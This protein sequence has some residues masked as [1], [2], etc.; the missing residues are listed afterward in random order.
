MA[1]AKALTYYDLAT[2]RAVKSFIV[3]APAAN[4]IKLFMAVIYVFSQ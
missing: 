4:P 1:V 3:L 2:I